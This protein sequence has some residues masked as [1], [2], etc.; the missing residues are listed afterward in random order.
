[1]QGGL[2]GGLSIAPEEAPPPEE[3]PAPPTEEA[4]APEA[5]AV[6]GGGEANGALITG[7]QA[8]ETSADACP[9]G[10]PTKAYGAMTNALTTTVAQFKAKHPNGNLSY[11]QLV[12]EVRKMLLKANFSQNP[13][14]E[15]GDE[16]V[17]KGFIV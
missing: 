7:C 15:C 10:D 5:A 4:P 9:G 6:P 12:N 13:C 3:A 8:H 17:S 11:A 14:L 1:M 16:T 2:L